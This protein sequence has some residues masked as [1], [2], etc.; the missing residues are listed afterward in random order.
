MGQNKFNF[1]P[2]DQDK[3]PS[4]KKELAKQNLKP[5]VCCCDFYPGIHPR[6][7]DCDPESRKMK[8][9]AA[10]KK[11]MEKCF[12]KD[13]FDGVCAACGKVVDEKVVLICNKQ[14]G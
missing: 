11:E 5:D 7:L 4:T 1:N 6:Y 9:N 14:N 10:D 12:H 2:E 3:T 8:L 13:T